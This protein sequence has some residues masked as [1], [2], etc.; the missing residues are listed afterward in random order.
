MTNTFIKHTKQTSDI[1][2]KVHNFEIT[3][4]NQLRLGENTAE[5]VSHPHCY[6]NS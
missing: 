6:V 1:S 3:D 2:I 4:A 5:V